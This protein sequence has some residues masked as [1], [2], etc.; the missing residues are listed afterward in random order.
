MTKQNSKGQ[1]VKG[2]IP[3]NKEKTGIYSK[4]TLQKMSKAS[5]K[6]T[7]WNKGTK[8]VCKPNS[9]SFQKGHKSTKKWQEVMKSRISEKNSSWKG[10]KVGYHALH[11]WVYRRKGKPKICVDCDT[12]CKERRISWSNVDHKYRRVLSDYQARCVPCHKK[13]D[14]KLKVDGG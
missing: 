6:R 10:N 9:G 5:Q 2:Q 12:T 3:W 11:K 7:P 13:Y 14:K 4:A 8:G 1:F